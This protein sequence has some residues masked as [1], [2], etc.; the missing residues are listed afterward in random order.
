MPKIID[1][2]SFCGEFDI[3][4]IRLN[5]LYDFVDQFIICEGD[6]TTAG[7]P[8]PRYFAENYER[9]TKWL[10]KIKYFIMAPYTDP[11]LSLLA[12]TSPGVPKDMHWW[13]REF[14]QKE[15][16]R[17]ALTHLHDND[18]VYIGDVDEIWDPRIVFPE[19]RWELNQRVYTHYLNNRSSEQWTGTSLMSYRDIKTDTLDNLRAYDVMRKHMLAPVFPNAGW[20]FT[21]IGGAEFIKRKI[22][23]YAHQEFN[24][25]QFLSLVDERIAQNVDYLG[26]DFKLGK[27]E[28]DL[29]TYLLDNKDKYAKLLL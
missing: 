7:V 24:N 17:Y 5:I 21:N 27:D 19:G 29:P 15:S 9:Y 6:E 12:D 11:A 14:I 10:P 4:E 23:S 2:F 3:L 1:I 8:K 18:R 16:M 20:H 22:R 13:R 28:S 25:E 26:R